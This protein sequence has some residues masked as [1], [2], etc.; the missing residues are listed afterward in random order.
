MKELKKLNDEANYCE[1]CLHSPC[2][3]GCPLENHITEF[4]RLIKEKNF[5]EAYHV[6]DETTVL[7][8]ICGRIC[9]HEK[10]CQGKCIKH[11]TDRSIKIG[12]L[13]A[14]IGDLANLNNW[15]IKLTKNEKLHQ[16]KVCVIGGGPAGLS[17]AA[18]LARNNISVT[19]Y[20]KHDYLGGLLRHG[21][22]EFRLNRKALDMTIKR[23][24][25]LDIKVE[26]NKELGKNIF[27]EDLQ[28]DY[29]AIFLGIGTNQ[30]KFMDIKGTDLNGVYGGNEL[31]E[32]QKHPNYLDK[33]VAI[34]GGGNVA[35]DTARTIKRLGAKNV[36]IIYRRSP[37]DMKA[38]QK[39][40]KNAKKEGIKF[41][42]NT[43]V[44]QIIGK[45]NVEKITIV[46]TE[47]I[48]GNLKNIYNTEKNIKVDYVVFTIGSTPNSKLISSLNIITNDNGTIKVD[49]K[50]ATSIS[51]VFA[52]GD[53]ANEIN[54][55][56][57]ASKSGRV[58][59]YSIIEYLS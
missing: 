33:N 36:I 30:S 49:E 26:Y 31:L 4:I 17:C 42:F 8:S 29:N 32:N 13:E 43:N 27:L 44:S 19:I 11:Y 41:L 55:V 47:E 6:L 15:P 10:L 22:P 38:D 9:P 14:Y 50:K 7:P 37:K 24:L 35:M 18:F 39:E 58:A 1:G 21:I 51:N 48:D 54:T 28:K 23:I 46:K 2:Q 16:K 25:D 34:V 57:N 53:V 40:L 45:N 12:A 56:S 5:E 59:A 3:K 20:E 52:G